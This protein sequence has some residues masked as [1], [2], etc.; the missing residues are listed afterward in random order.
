VAPGNA[1]SA[2]AFMATGYLPAGA[3][4]LLVAQEAAG[5]GPA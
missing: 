5:G 4:A 2:R 3:E 1:A